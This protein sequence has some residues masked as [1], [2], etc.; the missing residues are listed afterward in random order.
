MILAH[1]HSGIERNQREIQ[2]VKDEENSS[3]NNETCRMADI[4]V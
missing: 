1:E 2:T 3:G 4:I